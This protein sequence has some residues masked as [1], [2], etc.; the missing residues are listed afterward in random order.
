MIFDGRTRLT[1][2]DPV[3]SGSVVDY[4]S[5]TIEGPDLSASRQVYGGWSEGF[6]HLGRYFATLAE[7]WRGWDG[8]RTFESVESDLR[9]AATHDGRVHLAVMLWEST[10][11]RGWQAQAQLRIDAGEQLACAARDI[12]DLVGR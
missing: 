11:P 4:V 3:G 12:A 6:A 2:S 10:E 1:F 7:G 9:L 8:E 5:V